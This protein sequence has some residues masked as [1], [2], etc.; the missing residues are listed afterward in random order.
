MYATSNAIEA[1]K[2]EQVG[3]REQVVKRQGQRFRLATSLGSRSSQGLKLQVLDSV[4]SDSIEFSE[5]KGET[6]L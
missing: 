6:S 4:D 5:A 3:K 1:E 2:R